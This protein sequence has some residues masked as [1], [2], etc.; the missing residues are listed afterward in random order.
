MGAS[1]TL[2]Q[3]QPNGSRQTIWHIED[4]RSQDRQMRNAHA[5]PLIVS[6]LASPSAIA[7]T[8]W[9]NGETVPPWVRSSCCGVSDL[10][11]LTPD[12]VHGPFDLAEARRY[13]PNAQEPVIGGCGPEGGTCVT[14]AQMYV[15]DG[16]GYPV[17]ASKV[18]PSQDGNYWIFYRDGSPYV[19]CFFIPM[20]T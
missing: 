6:L 13:L 4:A 9:A 11:H 5:I 1:N 15:V 16:F 10:H 14:D 20:G 18:L 3:W 19:Y 2:F 7:H 8:V 17:P 12:M